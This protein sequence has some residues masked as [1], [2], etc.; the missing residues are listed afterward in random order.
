MNCHEQGTTRLLLTRIPFF[1][2]VVLMSF[3]CPHC[4]F[5]NSE[6]QSAGTIQE[7]GSRYTL[8]IDSADDLNRQIIKSETCVSSIPELDLEIPAQRGQL[9]NPEGLINT[10]LE[11]LADDQD[12][13]KE[14]DAEAW[15]QI[16]KFIE[17]G[18][19]FLEGKHFPFRL[20][21]DDPAGNSWIEPKPTDPRGKW[22]RA[23]Y[24]RTPEQNLK[25]GLT[26]TTGDQE[27]EKKEVDDVEIRP[28]EVHT[29]PATCP[30]CARPC[31]THMKLVDIPHFTEVIIMSTVCHDC[32]CEFSLTQTAR[33]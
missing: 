32:G 6:I 17:K 21:L 29:F 1:R 24:L 12:K 19:G 13:R 20:V 22:T 5:R 8:R 25:L 9:T 31:A 2:E 15:E 27:V 11:D 4:H 18:R 7:R 26:D 10:V 3:D 28:D 16:N 33:P 30:S 14:V 23:E